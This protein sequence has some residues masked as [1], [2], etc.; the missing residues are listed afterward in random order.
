MPR[1]ARELSKTG[2]YHVIM[3][4]INRQ[5]IFEDDEDFERFIETIERYKS[6]SKFE[7]YAYCLMEN[8]VHILI[9]EGEESLSNTIKRI[10]SS[11]VMRYNSKYG[12]VGHLFQDRFKSEPVET[13]RYFY[14]VLRYIFQNPIK[15]E[16]V[17]EVKKYQ[18]SNYGEY[19]ESFRS[20]DVNYV[21]KMFCQKED[22][23]IGAFEKFINQENDDKCLDISDRKNAELL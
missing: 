2:I 6:T 16:I 15:A 1:H 13:E 11:Y 19:F 7:L 20:D 21:L 17:D 10:S 3:R 9:K 18:W 5:T 12:R 22:E 8:H 14:A 23:A 4:G